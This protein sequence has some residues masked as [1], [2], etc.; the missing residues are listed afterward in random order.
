MDGILEIISKD[1]SQRLK[2]FFSCSRVTKKE[3]RSLDLTIKDVEE[4]FVFACYTGSLNCVLVL[5]KFG[6][7]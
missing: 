7:L 4:L 3:S 1:I 5:S 6:K 2:E